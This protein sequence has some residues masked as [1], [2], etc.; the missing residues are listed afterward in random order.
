[1]KFK[2]ISFKGTL[3]S[4]TIISLMCIL[5]MN[6]MNE[7]HEQAHAKACEYFGGNATITFNTQ[8]VPF[9]ETGGQTQCSINND[10][11]ITINA[12]HEENDYPLQVVMQLFWVSSVVIVLCTFAI[13]KKLDDKSVLNE[14]ELIA[15]ITQTE[16]E[17][18]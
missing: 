13:L 4:I 5:L 7:A 8:Y 1:M 16:E 15:T 3:L 2:F 14:T 6:S 12:I 10:Q 11:L 17:T 18:P 9:I